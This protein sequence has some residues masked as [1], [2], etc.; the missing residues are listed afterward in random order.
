MEPQREDIQHLTAAVRELTRA[1]KRLTSVLATATL[2]I[3][4]AI[5]AAKEQK[6]E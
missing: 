6:D 5:D 3:P 1:T 2:M 4:E